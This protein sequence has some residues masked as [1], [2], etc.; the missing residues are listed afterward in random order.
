MYDGYSAGCIRR[1]MSS[2]VVSLKIQQLAVKRL[3]TMEL[4]PGSV[5][6]PP[7]CLYLSLALS[8]DIDT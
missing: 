8:A 1:L 5:C 6:I 4:P 3:N 7:I 2:K